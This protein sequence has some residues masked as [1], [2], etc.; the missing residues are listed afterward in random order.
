MKNVFYVLCMMFCFSCSNSTDPGPSPWTNCNY[1]CAGQC[2]D[3]CAN[4]SSCVNSCEEACGCEP[5]RS[6][7]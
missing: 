3:R 2:P 4:E 5:T 7:A 1:T 6:G